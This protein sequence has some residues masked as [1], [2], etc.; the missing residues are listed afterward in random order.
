MIGFMLCCLIAFTTQMLKQ[1]IPTQQ[2]R[3][4]QEL[5]TAIYNA[6]SQE[7]ALAATESHINLVTPGL[8]DQLFEAGTKSDI[9]PKKALSL[10]EA[11]RFCAVKINDKSLTLKA[12]HKIGRLLYEGG[13]LSEA[14]G[15]LRQAEAEATN[16]HNNSA[17]VGIYKDIAVTYRDQGKYDESEGFIRRSLSLSKTLHDV[18]GEGLAQLV[19]ATLSQKRGN[20]DDALIYLNKA[21]PLF[22]SLKDDNLSAYALVAL[23]RLAAT[24]SDYTKANQYYSDALKVSEKS[25]MTQIAIYTD[26][27]VLYDNQGD[28][29]NMLTF[30]NKSLQI[31]RA[32]E[33]SF[34][35]ASN[36]LGIGGAY[37]NQRNYDQALQNFRESIAIAEK[38]QAREILAAAQSE[39]G[40]VYQAQKRCDESLRY[41]L[42]SLD[43]AKAID[44]KS[45]TGLALTYLASVSYEMKDS[46]GALK[47]AIQAA[48]LA[49]KLNFPEQIYTALTVLGKI[50]HS[51]KQDKLA[52]QVLTEA[53]AAVEDTRSRVMGGAQAKQLYFENKIEP[54]HLLIEIMMK[55]GDLQS[56]LEYAEAARARVLSDV[57]LSGRPPVPQVMTVE[58]RNEE[59][60]LNERLNDLNA[61]ISQLINE[62][63]AKEKTLQNIREQRQIAR[64]D[65][66]RFKN[67]LYD[68]HPELKLK[69]TLMQPFTLERVKFLIQG[70]NS[71]L[72]EYVVGQEQV[73]LFVLTKK[74]SGG[75]E[76]PSGINLQTYS[77][78]IKRDQLNEKVE[79]FRQRLADRDFR[80]KTLGRE[81]Y[82]LLVKPAEEQIKGHEVL[83]I[84]P[85]GILWILPFAALL[86]ESNR[87]LVED[88]APV[89]VPSLNVLYEMEHSYKGERAD[90]NRNVYGVKDGQRQNQG[91]PRPVNLFVIGNPSSGAG[92]TNRIP[93]ND[94]SSLPGTTQL[95]TKLAELYGSRDN[96]KFALG[97]EATE[98]VF[99]SIAP[100]ARIIHVISHGIFDDRNPMFSYLQLN[101]S[102][103]DDG[104][105]DAME[106]MDIPLH[107][108]SLVVL[109]ACETARGRVGAGES[110][111][112]MSW[113]VFIAGC[114]TTVLSQWKV[115]AFST[116]MLMEQFYQNLNRNDDGR[117]GVAKALRK[118]SIKFLQDEN[119]KHP[120]YW[121]GLV[122]MGDGR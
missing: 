73:L 113:S 57:I 86:P 116:N 81:L 82:D 74:P 95:A 112:G 76:D 19:L 109:S 7:E 53:V 83:E 102:S 69:G 98:G 62:G 9:G 13:Q 88:Y 33:D 104:Q 66:M 84:A 4:Q 70:S 34:S 120:M 10:F 37:T 28:Y 42:K 117:L 20:Y 71:A 77:I 8:C 72:L 58:E 43:N 15:L 2:I 18:K 90:N 54:Y 32:H 94:N 118:A 67:N 55:Q 114:P 111:I 65:L 21:L 105:L 6:Q 101:K 87:Y 5:F 12:L 97:A 89:Y 64:S 46:Q 44:D 38:I 52:L 108:T 25:P 63:D 96:V 85:D 79:S 78:P 36:L 29:E 16:E 17:L 100:S 22:D 91:E 59:Q 40:R 3:T 119:Y 45:R 60:K 93:E 14:L 122:V 56:A 50:Y 41:Y 75:S 68:A 103:N 106:I 107:S 31:A 27:G 23:A 115:P 11:S 24:K 48:E 26:L 51:L 47:Y 1:N 92:S 110:L 99:K 39:I 49:K 121:A 35:I 30:Y 80:Y 61:Q